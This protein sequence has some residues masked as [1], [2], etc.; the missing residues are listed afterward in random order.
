[1][2]AISR[3]GLMVP[4]I[5]DVCGHDTSRVLLVSKV[6]SSAGSQTGFFG[7]EAAHHFTLKPNRSAT[8]THGAMLAS[9]LSLDRMS[10]SPGWNV[11]AIE[12]LCSSW[13]V[14]TP[15]LICL[16]CSYLCSS[17]IYIVRSQWRYTSS[18][19]ALMNPAATLYAFEYAFVE[20]LETP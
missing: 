20:D 19:A 9:W 10:S 12:M 4:V 13:V 16:N 14:E 15:I 8:W 1:M 2:S 17:G 18:V 7:S 5:L 3:T 6:F 11:R